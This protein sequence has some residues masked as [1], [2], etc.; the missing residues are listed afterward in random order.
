MIRVLRS[1]VNHDLPG[2]AVGRALTGYVAILI[3]VVITILVQSSSVV[4]SALTP[5]CGIGILRVERMYP[6]T[7]GANVGTTF[8]SVLAA[9]ASPPHRLHVSLQIAFC[10]LLFNA[11][12][13]LIFYAIPPMRHLPLTMVMLV[14]GM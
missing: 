6:L 7:L 14:V 5:L 4:T 3:G 2:G 8:T 13:I 11:T 9:M 12:G 10:H 1:F